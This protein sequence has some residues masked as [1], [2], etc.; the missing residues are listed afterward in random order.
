[1]RMRSADENGVLRNPASLVNQ[2][3]DLSDQ[4]TRN[5]ESV[6]A[7]KRNTASAIV[8]NSHAHFAGVVERAVK[9]LSVA[10]WLL[11]ADVRGNVA[12]GKARFEAGAFDML[13]GGWRRR[14]CRSAGEGRAHELTSIHM[15]MRSAGTVCGRP[16]AS[17]RLG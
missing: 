1:M 4:T 16:L 13:S 12:L 10:A 14:D 17:A 11:H 3:A 8:E 5:H 15:L 7:H 6:D 9:D 2:P